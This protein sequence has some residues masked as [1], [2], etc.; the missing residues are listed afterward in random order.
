[1]EPDESDIALDELEQ[2]LERL[3]SLY[4]QY[5]LGI[6]KVEP[7]IARKDVDRRFW[8]L[9]RTKLRN[10]ARRFRMQ[11]LVQRY[12]TFQQYWMRICRQ[13]EAGTYIRHVIRAEKRFG[14]EAV[15]I[16]AKRRETALLKA[17]EA[18]DAARSGGSASQT[19]LAAAAGSSAPPPSA[20]A[21]SSAPPSAGPPSSDGVSTKTTV[22]I[23]AV[24][25]PGVRRADET[26][27]VEPRP[28]PKRIPR[29]EPDDAEIE[30]H[31][32]P[33]P[34]A[35]SFYNKPTTKLPAIPAAGRG[36]NI[37]KHLP[38]APNSTRFVEQPPLSMTPTPGSTTR[39]SIP[40]ARRPTPNEGGPDLKPTLAQTRV[41][42]AASAP[43]GISD[44]RV[45]ELHAQLS[46]EKKR[47]ADDSPVSL[48]GL[49]KS[50]NET[51]A[52]LKSMHGTGKQ[53]DFRVVVKGGKAMVKPVLK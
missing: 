53:V 52:K 34:P 17:R 41:A 10:T 30:I 49:T 35:M 39:F 44:K 7:T 1:V 8:L 16:A 46:A 4:E 19:N 12:N 48:D 22:A 23:P 40:A 42:P 24:R 5:F 21:Q 51:A 43:G 14:R 25:I 47:L 29:E 37:G 13:I 33:V 15:T 38:P 50:L 27:P 45:A 9:R 32:T 20:G 18:L 6:E 28:R 31:D 26:P 2:R 36:E 3:R 11:L